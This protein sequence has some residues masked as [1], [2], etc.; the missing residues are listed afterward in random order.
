GMILGE[1]IYEKNGKLYGEKELGKN[2]LKGGLFL[3]RNP[4]GLSKDEAKKLKK[5]YKD[6]K[7]ATENVK[8]STHTF[9]APYLF[10]GTMLTIIVGGNLFVLIINVI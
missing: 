3:K 2:N 5:A 1:N 9:F 10:A 7:F 4:H 8:V 6:N